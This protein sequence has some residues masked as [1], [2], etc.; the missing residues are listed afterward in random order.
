MNRS[1]AD[2]LDDIAAAIAS[3]S[4]HLLHGPI[5]VESVMDAV[6]MRLLEIGEAVKAISPDLT[7]TEPDIPWSDIGRMRDC[8]VTKPTRSPGP[9]DAPFGLV[10]SPA[11]FRRATS[12]SLPSASAA[13]RRIVRAARA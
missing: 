10:T 4:S 2:R 13:W 1:D 9:T 6:A 12:P 8:R 5:S 7:A 3:I 11:H